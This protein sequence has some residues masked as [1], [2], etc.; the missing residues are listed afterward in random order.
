LLAQAKDPKSPYIANNLQ[1]LDESA[2]KAKA[3][4]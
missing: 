3:I 2:R 1:M 4:N